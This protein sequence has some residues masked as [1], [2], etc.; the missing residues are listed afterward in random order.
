[1][2]TRRVTRSYTYTARSWMFQL[3][4]WLVIIIGA[5][6]A[7]VGIMHAAGISWSWFDR[8]ANWVKAICFTIGMFI[9]VV[10]SYQVA[11]H[12]G[13]V[14]FVLWIIFVILVV[15]GLVTSLI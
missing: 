9:P 2:A 1:M 5:A 11:R 3:A 4:F 10:M 15:V 7:I 6:M 13:T 12:K 14:W 8:F